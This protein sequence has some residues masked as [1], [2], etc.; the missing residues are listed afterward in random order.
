[1]NKKEKKIV[2]ILTIVLILLDQILKIINLN[3]P[4]II[5]ERTSNNASYI[6]LSII[7]IIVIIRYMSNNNS[8]IK[9]SSRVVLSFALAGAI[10]NII[11]RIW[12]GDVINYIEIPGVIGVNLSYI[13]I[14]IAWVGM[15][16][17]LTK[18]TFNE[19]KRKREINN[20][21]K[22]NNSSRKK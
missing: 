15:A 3:K 20:G 5:R 8:F 21:N 18:Y 12:L 17:I 16:V 6:I 7:V 11:D 22:K 19:S 4:G 2:I 1:M 13:Y 10:S 9:T 14:A